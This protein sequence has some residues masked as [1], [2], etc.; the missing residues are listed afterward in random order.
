MYG[1]GKW[2]RIAPVGPKHL[3]LDSS[4]PGALE[5]ACGIMSDHVT[6]PHPRSGD[7]ARHC[8]HCDAW[9]SGTSQLRPHRR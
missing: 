3:M 7:V 8:L 9:V 4:Q 2:W 1:P 6:S 5:F